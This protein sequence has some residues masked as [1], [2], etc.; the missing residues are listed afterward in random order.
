MN[1]QTKRIRRGEA[2]LIAELEAK[3]ESLKRR[4]EEKK[5]KRDPALRH[6]RMALRSIDKAFTGTEDN[7]M[8][9]ALGEARATLSACL[10]LHGVSAAPKSGGRGTITP[11]PRGLADVDEGQLLDYIQ[12]HPG[13][14]GEEIANALGTDTKTMRPK[15]K[16]LIEDRRV[17]TKGQA[18][19]MQYYPV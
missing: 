3:I 2:E 13:Q 16:R 12:A 15:V 4:A 18:R 17:K 10:S 19:G 1:N 14:R 5:A 7:A 8:R 6:V 11:R 9:T